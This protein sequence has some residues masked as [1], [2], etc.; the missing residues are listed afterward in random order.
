MLSFVC[1]LSTKGCHADHPYSDAAVAVSLS[2]LPFGGPVTSCHPSTPAL[3]L[4]VARPWEPTLEG[5]RMSGLDIFFYF[6][7]LSHLQTQSALLRKGRLRLPRIAW[8]MG[9]WDFSQG[10]NPV[11]QGLSGSEGT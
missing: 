4:P 3:A 1:Q 8:F 9:T 11:S 6:N 2:S 5:Q 10:N 7:L